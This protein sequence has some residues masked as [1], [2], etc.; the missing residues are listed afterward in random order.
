[1]NSRKQVFKNK[2]P[3]SLYKGVHKKSE[4][5]NWTA[6]IGLNGKIFHLGSFIREI[7]AAKAYDRKA[8]ELFGKFARL[9]FTN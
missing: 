1:M 2:V 8:K 7:D 5:R 6:Q 3:T 4:K 9:N